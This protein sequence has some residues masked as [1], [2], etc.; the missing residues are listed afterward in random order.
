MTQMEK[1]FQ[2]KNLAEM[3]DSRGFAHLHYAM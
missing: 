1:G 3:L 2:R